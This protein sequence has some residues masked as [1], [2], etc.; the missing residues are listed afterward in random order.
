MT[1]EH[2]LLYS[3]LKARKG[4]EG[5]RWIEGDWGWES[6][7]RSFFCIYAPFFVV[8]GDDDSSSLMEER[9]KEMQWMKGDLL[10]E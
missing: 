10:V 7:E 9:E 8:V 1:Q 3:R 2:Q 4:G 5:A 6:G